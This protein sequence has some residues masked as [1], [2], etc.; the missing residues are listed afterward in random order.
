MKQLL[1]SLL[2]ISF[3]GTAPAYALEFWHSNTVWANQGQCSAVF[4]FDSG[5]EEITN[6]QV[7]VSAL[8]KTGKKVASGVLEIP[9]L[10]QSEADRYANAFL[11]GEEVCGSDLTIVV[12]K[13]TALIGG[14]PTDLLKS[15][16]L[17]VRDFK[18]FTIRLGK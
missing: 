18:P 3:C 14:Q 7:W 11:E 5:M 17:S 15:T 4:S 12:N 9:Q 1:S 8:N 6:L 16:A 13:A 10:G 2:V